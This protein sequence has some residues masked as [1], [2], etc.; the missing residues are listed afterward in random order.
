MA[1]DPAV[2]TAYRDQ[3]REH[4]LD[5][6]HPRLQRLPS[7][8]VRRTPATVTVGTY[9]AAVAVT[10]HPHRVRGRPRIRRD[11]DRLGVR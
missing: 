10:R 11:R 9:P 7:H 5:A 1:A 6:Q 8:R 2:D 4:R 3:R